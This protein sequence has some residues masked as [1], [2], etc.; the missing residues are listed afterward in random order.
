MKKARTSEWTRPRDV[1]Q[2]MGTPVHNIPA[3][4]DDDPTDI[5]ASYLNSNAI[6]ELQQHANAVIAQRQREFNAAGPGRN[7]MGAIDEP[8][9]LAIYKRAQRAVR[10][11]ATTRAGRD[12][13]A[14]QWLRNP[15]NVNVADVVQRSTMTEM[16]DEGE[17]STRSRAMHRQAVQESQRGEQYR[18][19]AAL[20][21]SRQMDVIRRRKL[22]EQEE[23]W[24]E[25]V[26]RDL[27][28]G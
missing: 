11:Q 23:F 19:G 5:Y 17:L 2:P 26:N 15:S 6:D 22:A 25:S 13:L 12:A 24:D 7:M 21:A 28:G 16:M 27:Q 4:Y 14:E 18:A 10:H 1:V 9:L 20:E 8:L 3:E